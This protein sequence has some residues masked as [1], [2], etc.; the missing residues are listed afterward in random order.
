MGA[1]FSSVR[2][3]RRAMV[4]SLADGMVVRGVFA[5]RRRVREGNVV[6]IGSRED[7]LVGRVDFR[8]RNVVAG[9]AV[10]VSRVLMGLSR[11]ERLTRAGRL[12]KEPNSLSEV[13][14]LDER[15]SSFNF[16]AGRG[17]GILPSPLHDKRRV[18]NDGNDGSKFKIYIR[19]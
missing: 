3:G 15:S 4:R 18:S 14:L 16:G 17:P 8:S 5:V 10:S 1:Q 13:I 11:R 7:K 12:A 2:V 6:G 19:N 9:N